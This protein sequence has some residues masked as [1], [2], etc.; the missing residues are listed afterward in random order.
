MYSGK[1]TSAAVGFVYARRNSSSVLVTVRLLA[2]LVSR[3]ARQFWGKVD[4][5]L[6]SSQFREI[7]FPSPDFLHAPPAEN[8]HPIQRCSSLA[9]T[10]RDIIRTNSGNYGENYAFLSIA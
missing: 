2:G 1:V 9:E 7:R 8:R 10:Y 6:P 3:S 4:M 5:F